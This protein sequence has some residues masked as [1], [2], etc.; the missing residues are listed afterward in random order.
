MQC[1]V[2]VMGKNIYRLLAKQ[3]LKVILNAEPKPKE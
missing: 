3:E 1:M 2:A